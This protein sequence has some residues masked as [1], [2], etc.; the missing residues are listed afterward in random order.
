MSAIEKIKKELKPNTNAKP[1]PIT[2]A[3]DPL[4][5]ETQVFEMKDMYGYL[6]STN[7]VF[8]IAAV[9]NSDFYLKIPKNRL[10]YC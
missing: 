6:L 8:S 9:C 1:Q 7:A 3:V 10:P 2:L 4:Q 5:K